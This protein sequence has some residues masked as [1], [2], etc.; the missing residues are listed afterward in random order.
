LQNEGAASSFSFV[1]AAR[2]AETPVIDQ[3]DEPATA[4]GASWSGVWSQAD[5]SSENAGFDYRLL[6]G[7][8]RDDFGYSNA[9]YTRQLFAGGDQGDFGAFLQRDRKLASTLRITFGARIDVWDETAGH[10]NIHSIRS[11]GLLSADRYSDNTGTEFSPSV[12]LLWRPTTNLTMHANWQQSFSRPTLSELYQPIGQDAVVTEANPTLRTEHNTSLE[13]GAQY[14]VRLK[15]ADQ[16]PSTNPSEKSPNQSEGTLV[17]EV[18]AF[19]NQLHDEIGILSMDRAPDGFPIF[20]SLP[21]GYIGQQ[22]INL[23]RAR[24]QGIYL[25][26]A[27]HIGSSFS[28]SAAVLFDDPR[29]GGVSEAPEIAGKQIAGVSRHTASIGATWQATARL[30]FRSRLRLLGPKFQD[31]ENTLRLAD[32][33][34]EDFGATYVLTRQVELFLAVDNLSD[35]DVDISRSAEG[36]IYKSAPRMFREGLRLSW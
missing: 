31:D 35:A 28:L 7:E 11:G 33:I 20:G 26:G 17:F 5:G 29:I 23:D 19:S 2:T 18:T 24:I 9:A 34:V 30:A 8:A 12:G 16:G 15:A 10:Q 22:R 32:A 1:N 4:Y 36:V 27:W 21:A 13:F 14:Q 3:L 25:S 6:H